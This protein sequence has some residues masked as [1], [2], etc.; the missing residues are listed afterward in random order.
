MEDGN[1]EEER[2]F[3]CPAGIPETARFLQ[4]LEA[5]GIVFDACLAT[6]DELAAGA[7]KYALNAGK[8]IPE[9][10][11]ITGY[12]NSLLS[13]CSTP[14]I[15][16]ADNRVEFLCTTAVSLLMQVLEGKDVPERTMYS[17]NLIRRATTK[18]RELQP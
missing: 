11:Q 17:A 12:N 7:V 13:I 9:D 10:I 1:P 15:T 8:R 4:E 14:E 6:D 2:S 3:L 5:R 16:T 18:S